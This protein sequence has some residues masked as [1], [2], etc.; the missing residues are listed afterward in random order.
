MQCEFSVTYGGGCL[1]EHDTWAEVCEDAE[2]A[3]V[4]ATKKT[5]LPFTHDGSLLKNTKQNI[6][7]LVD[8]AQH[9]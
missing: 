9:R 6:S 3:V 2:T 5:M 4:K 7:T 8:M 1:A